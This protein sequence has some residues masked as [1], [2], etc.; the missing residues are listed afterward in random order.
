MLQTDRTIHTVQLGEGQRVI[1]S[2][3]VAGED[4]H[5]ATGRR[6]T[7]S[8]EW[9]Q[10]SYSVQLGGGILSH[11]GAAVAGDDSHS[12]TGKGIVSHTECCSGSRS[13]TQCNWDEG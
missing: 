9:Q 3:A 11:T 5:S 1:L 8:N 7:E 2:A 13:F 10:I 12:A 4:S 6:D